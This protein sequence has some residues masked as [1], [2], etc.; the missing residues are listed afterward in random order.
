MKARALFAAAVAVG[1]AG[2]AGAALAQQSISVRDN[3]KISIQASVTDVTRI[4]LVGDDRIRR[5]VKDTT[6]FQEINDEETGD[7]FLRYSGDQ[8]KLVPETGFI[9]TEQGRTIGYTLQPA[10][11]V[12]NQTILIS[13]SGGGGAAAS[14]NAATAGAGA[15]PVKQSF[16]MEAT[17]ASGGSGYADTLVAFVRAAIVKHAYGRQAPNRADGAV[18]ATVAGSG[19]RARVIVVSGGARG[20][21]LAERN[22]QGP[23]TLAVWLEKQSLFPGER[24]W[25]IIVDRG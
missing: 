22:F 13:V 24:A 5:I 25:A 9:I 11:N 21:E 19:M 18:I 10:T 4:S 3:G 1:L 16:Q 7:V 17:S 2:T 12:G 15:A 14:R 8:A 6:S 23:K 20:R